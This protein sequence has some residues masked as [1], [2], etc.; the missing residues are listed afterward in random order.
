MR[1]VVAPTTDER[2]KF[3]GVVRAFPTIWN[4]D[5]LDVGSRSGNLRRALPAGAGGYRSI[6]LGPPA[7]VVADIGRG[8]PVRERTFDTVVALDVL[9]HADDIHRAFGE[10][11]RVSASHVLVTLPNA[12]EASARMRYLLGR[13]PS[14]KYGLPAEPPADRHRWLFSLDDA[15]RFL[16]ALAPRCGFELKDE[17]CLVGPRRGVRMVRDLVGRFPNLLAGTYVALL[18]RASV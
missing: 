16:R 12:F 11:C 4:G 9:E 14:G 6:D 15:R 5:V 10:L 18:G 8:L 7:D 13:A 3:V 2:G 1:L 17:G